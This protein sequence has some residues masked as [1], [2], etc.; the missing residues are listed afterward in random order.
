MT[1]S[2]V[3]AQRRMRVRFARRMQAHRSWCA[4]RGIGAGIPAPDPS[5]ETPAMTETECAIE[6]L[7]RG[8]RL[9][10]RTAA[11][12][13]RHV[14]RRIALTRDPRTWAVR[15]RGYLVPLAVRTRYGI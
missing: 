9:D 2:R 3:V 15:L 10:P 6:Q 13:R 1:Y 11:V 7:V 12:L 8:Y 14:D 5:Q 4:V